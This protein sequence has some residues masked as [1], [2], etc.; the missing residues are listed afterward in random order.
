LKKTIQKSMNER[1][2]LDEKV[3]TRKRLAVEWNVSEGL[4][5]FALT[6][7]ARTHNIWVAK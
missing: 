2:V 5:P 3:P 6:S 7:M 1:R 4:I